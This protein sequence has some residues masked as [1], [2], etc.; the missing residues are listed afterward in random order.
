MNMPTCHKPYYQSA[1]VSLANTLAGAT[2]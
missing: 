1:I 2:A